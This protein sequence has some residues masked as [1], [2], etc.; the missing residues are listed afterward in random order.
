MLRDS[1]KQ[2][3]KQ[4]FWLAAMVLGVIVILPIAIPIWAIAEFLRW[5]DRRKSGEKGRIFIGKT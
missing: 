5:R 4:W 3:V 2:S 1:T